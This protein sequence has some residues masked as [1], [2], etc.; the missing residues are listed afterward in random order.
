MKLTSKLKIALKSLLSVELA[1]TETDKAVLV[2]DGELAEGIEVFVKDENAEDGVKPAEDGTYET[3]TQI[4]EVADGKITKITGKEDKEDEQPVEKIEIEAKQVF[5]KKK[6]VFEDTYSDKI[7]KIQET[8]S[9][10]G[11]DC[12]IIDASDSYAIAE[13]WNED[14]ATWKDYRF[15]ISWD[16]DGNAVADD[17]VEVKHEYVTVDEKEHLEEVREGKIE[18]EEQ[19]IDAPEAEPAD[20]PE[21]IVDEPSVE[22]RLNALETLQT[23]IKDALERL[24]NGLSGLEGRIDALEEKVTKLDE[25]PADEP[26]DEEVEVEENHTKAYYLRKQK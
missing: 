8:I 2:Y 16:E 26:A 3:E 19:P 10:K 22:D 18:L 21:V 13:V 17:G 15:E 4:I 12:Y 11:F 5:E 14:N 24:L 25:T 7:R 23:E 1:E 20:E 6:A 9:S